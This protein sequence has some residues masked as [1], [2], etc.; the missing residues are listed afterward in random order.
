MMDARSTLSR[1]PTLRARRPRRLTSLALAP[2][3]ALLVA[4]V[5]CSG[6]PEIPDA[7]P[8][9]SAPPLFATEEEAL[10]AATAVYE[11]YLA[12]SNQVLADGGSDPDRVARFLS[13]ELFEAEAAGFADIAEQ[14]ISFKGG[15][16]ITG[17]LL[18]QVSPT[19]EG[20]AD[21]QL[22][23]CVTND[24]T[25]RL[26][27]DGLPTTEQPPAFLGTFEVIVNFGTAQS[28]LINRKDF[29]AEGDQCAVE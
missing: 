1:M 17:F 12:V 3:A 28:P 4:L 25:T 6:T 9:P 27:S 14:G 29:W 10:E 18:Q 19:A 23:V 21:V 20:G 8:A 22:Y 24:G 5:G 16:S 26:G 11:E 15:T 13:P 7:D 2:A